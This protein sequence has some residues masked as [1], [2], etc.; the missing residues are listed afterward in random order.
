ME[1]RSWRK[2]TGNKIAV[3][4]ATHYKGQTKGYEDSEREGR[5]EKGPP[6]RESLGRC[7]QGQ[8]I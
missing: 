8:D 2:H 6:E 1:R 7:R 4:D 3:T 5:E